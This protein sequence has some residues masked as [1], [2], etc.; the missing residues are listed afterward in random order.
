MMFRQKLNNHRIFKRLAKA[1]ISLRVCAGWS[2]PLLVAHTT[3][4]DITCHGPFHLREAVIRKEKSNKKSLIQEIFLKF[5]KSHPRIWYIAA[6]GMAA[7]SRETPCPTGIVRPVGSN[8]RL[9]G[10]GGG[11]HKKQ[12][13]IG[14]HT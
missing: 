7:E 6:G 11:T 1:L 10:G 4:L 5:F 14:G 9:G 3:L 12:L 8:Y 2:A 13:Q